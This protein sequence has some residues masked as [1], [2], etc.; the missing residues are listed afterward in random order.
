MGLFEVFLIVIS[1]CTFE[2]DWS[3]DPVPSENLLDISIPKAP[4]YSLRAKFLVRTL[5]EA[6]AF[7][8]T[9]A[10]SLSNGAKAVESLTSAITG[11]LESV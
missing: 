9:D 10:S 4:E 1:T 2:P 6:E 8:V 3:I 5:S 7:E 11:V